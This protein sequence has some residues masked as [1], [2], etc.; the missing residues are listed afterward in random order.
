MHK[1]RQGRVIEDIQMF[2]QAEILEDDAEPAAQGG[3]L[4]AVMRPDGFAKQLD[5]AGGRFL[6][7]I[8]HL[9]QRGLARS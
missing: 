5:H 6:R 9:E 1:Q 8:D 3:G 2:K 7:Q 4:G